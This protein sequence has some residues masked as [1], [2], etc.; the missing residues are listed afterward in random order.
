MKKLLLHLLCG[1]FFSNFAFSQE[2]KGWPSSERYSFITECLKSAKANLSEDSARFYCYCM[3][4][5]LEIKYPAIEDAS[6]LTAADLSGPEWRKEIQSCRVGIGQWSPKDRS[7]FLNDCVEAAKPSLGETKAKSYCE[8][9]L[10]K[11][12]KKYPDPA[13]AAMITEA[14]LQTPEFKKMIKDCADF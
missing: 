9:M 10:F 11:T 7:D 14:T 2:R 13:E 3:Q 1:V 6:K 8:C 4:E 5:K 12:E